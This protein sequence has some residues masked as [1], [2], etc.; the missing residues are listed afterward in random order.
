MA[1]AVGLITT[2]GC[3]YSDRRH[4]SLTSKDL[5]Q[6]IN[7]RSALRIYPKI[8]INKNIYGATYRVQF[9]NVLLY[10]WLISIGLTANKS[11][12]IGPLSIPNK[13]FGD[14][15]RGHLDGDGSITTYE[16]TY[17]QKNGGI[18]VY[19]RLSVRF[20]SASQTHIQWLQS[21]VIEIF[22]VAGRLHKT[23][24]NKIG[25]SMYI[26]KFGK[27]DSLELLSKIYYSNE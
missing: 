25:N 20:I 22:H 2:D 13:Y 3:L 4:I 6:I 5:E 12:S 7:I 11:L 26:L 19:N 17:T 10:D 23:K 9:S 1:Y 27:I 18:N 15:L 24:S 14:F 21:K 8:G 16:E